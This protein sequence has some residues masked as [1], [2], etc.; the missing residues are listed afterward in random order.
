MLLRVQT[1][2]TQLILTLALKKVV[3]FSK[4]CTL[5]SVLVT[6]ALVVSKETERIHLNSAHFHACPFSSV[7]F[8]NMSALQCPVARLKVELVFCLPAYELLPLIIL[9]CVFE[10]S[11]EGI[12]AFQYCVCDLKHRKRFTFQGE[13]CW[14]SQQPLLMIARYPAHYNNGYPL[15]KKIIIISL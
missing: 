5:H 4:R 3:P 10:N 6:L 14:L 15:Q 7:D 12:K 9:S 8:K 1:S 13:R 11:K 2:S